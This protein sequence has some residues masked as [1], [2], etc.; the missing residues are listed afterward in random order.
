MPAPG[1][2]E[3]FE[4]IMNAPARAR[5]TR[6]RKNPTCQTLIFNRFREFGL[7]FSPTPGP[8]ALTTPQGFDALF[9]ASHGS[10]YGRSPHGMMAAFKRPTARTTVPGLYL[11]GAGR[12]RGRGCRWR[13]SPAQHAAAA[14][15]TDLASTSTSRR[16]ATPGGMSTGSATAGRKR[17]LSSASSDRSFRRG[18][19]GPGGATRPTTAASTWRPTAPAGGSP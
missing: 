6:K 9:P 17:S 8:E 14:I 7:T 18:M 12:I 10:L 4:I 2:L 15:M 13:P 3:R 1:D 11:A 16:T 19:R 5:M